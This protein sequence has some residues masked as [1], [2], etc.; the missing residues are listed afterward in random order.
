MFKMVAENVIFN[1]TKALHPLRNEVD[2]FCLFEE[3]KEVLVSIFEKHC[4]CENS[5]KRAKM[6]R[7]PASALLEGEVKIWL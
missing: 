7:I 3:A 6:P 5:L 1:A 4:V 2:I